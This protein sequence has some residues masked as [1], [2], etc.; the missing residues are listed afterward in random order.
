MC[1]GFVQDVHRLCKVLQHIIS[2]CVVW[3][4]LSMRVLFPPTTL[5]LA[6]MQSG[7]HYVSAWTRPASQERASAGSTVQCAAGVYTCLPNTMGAT[8][9]GVATSVAWLQMVDSRSG[10]CAVWG[11][12]LS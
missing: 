10:L 2:G 1:S 7:K 11:S 4:A 6:V 9:R 5:Q 8:S 12:H 3:G